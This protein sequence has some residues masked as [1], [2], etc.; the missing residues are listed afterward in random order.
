MK[1][2]FLTPYIHK[3]IWHRENHFWVIDV[4]FSQVL[5]I[6]VILMNCWHGERGDVN[7]AAPVAREEWMMQVAPLSNRELCVCFC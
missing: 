7:P 6:K 5:L 1:Y 2:I 4:F 3:Y